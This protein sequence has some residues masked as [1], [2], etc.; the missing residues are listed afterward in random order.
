MPSPSKQ[1]TAKQTFSLDLSIKKKGI[2]NA[3]R[4]TITIS[5][6]DVLLSDNTFKLLQD[7]HDGNEAREMFIPVQ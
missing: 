1:F 5:N 7:I 6:F 3:I 2:Q 4:K